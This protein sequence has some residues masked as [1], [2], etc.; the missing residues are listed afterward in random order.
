MADGRFHSVRV[1]KEKYEVVYQDDTVI[2]SEEAMR[3]LLSISEDQ[4][5][6]EFEGTARPLLNLQRG[7]VT[8]FPLTALRRVVSWQETGEKIIVETTLTSNW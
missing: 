1:I 7:K 5:T 8:I 6:L 4:E 2:V 3:S